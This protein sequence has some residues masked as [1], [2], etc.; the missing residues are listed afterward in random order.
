MIFFA[1]KHNTPFFIMGMMYPFKMLE[2][3]IASSHVCYP[4]K[5]ILTLLAEDFSI[6][7]MNGTNI[8]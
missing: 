4:I 5:D 1:Q 2:Y 3:D 8:L 6:M 7:V